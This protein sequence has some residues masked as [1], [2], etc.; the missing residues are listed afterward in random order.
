M[1]SWHEGLHIQHVLLGVGGY[2]TLNGISLGDIWYVPT[3]S[4]FAIFQ[5]FLMFW[6]NAP[7]I[8]SGGGG[9]CVCF[10]KSVR[11]SR[12]NATSDRIPQCICPQK[13][14]P[15]EDNVGQ[16]GI[17]RPIEDAVFMGPAWCSLFR[18]HAPLQPNLWLV[19]LRAGGWR[20][21]GGG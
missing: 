14:C 8:R 20:Q 19:S 2:S 1:E 21:V 6:S 13:R 12:Y 9:V 10:L 5:G 4:K 7:K 17:C 15:P 3:R 18:L 11:K 16:K